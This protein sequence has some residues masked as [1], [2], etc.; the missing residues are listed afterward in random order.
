MIQLDDDWRLRADSRQWTLE[1]KAPGKDKDGN[2]V[3]QPRGYFQMLS[4]ALTGY[5]NQA[6][7]HC[8]SVDTLID[9]IA[10]MREQFDQDFS[11]EPATSN[12]EPD[13]FD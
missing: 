12:T 6:A 5:V 1:K 2:D 10:A 13:F 8:Q 4:Q 9:R 7:K 3:W 11:Y